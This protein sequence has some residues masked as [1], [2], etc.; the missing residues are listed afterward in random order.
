MCSFDA[1]LWTAEQ[2]ACLRREEDGEL[3]DIVDECGIDAGVLLDEVNDYKPTFE[4]IVAQLSLDMFLQSTARNIVEDS[5]ELVLEAAGLDGRAT[6][7]Q[8]NGGP[9]WESG[10]IL[11]GVDGN[12]IQ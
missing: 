2:D 11:P 6:I 7:D 10:I 9:Y 8:I 3:C 1:S 4:I 5:F 12:V